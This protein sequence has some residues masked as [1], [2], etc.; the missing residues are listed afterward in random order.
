M[1]GCITSALTDSSAVEVVGAVLGTVRSKAERG[2]E[3]VA[4]GGWKESV[5]LDV[6]RAFP[7]SLYG[8]WRPGTTA[9]STAVPS[10]L[11]TRKGH[12]FKPCRAHQQGSDQPKRC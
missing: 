3:A 11:L 2:V 1:G 6:K 7:F 12:R 9:A 10:V 8:Q 5:P 4:A